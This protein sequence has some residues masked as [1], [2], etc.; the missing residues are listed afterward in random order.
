VTEADLMGAA[1]AALQV[2]LTTSQPV[3]FYEQ[4]RGAVE[5][6]G[7]PPIVVVESSR[8]NPP[9]AEISGVS[10]TPELTLLRFTNVPLGD[11]LGLENRVQALAR[12]APVSVVEY[13]A[14]ALVLQVGMSPTALQ[15][16]LTG[17]LL[18]E[19]GQIHSNGDSVTVERYR[20][21]ETVRASDGNNHTPE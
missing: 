21:A 3:V 16:A 19:P 5:P 15:D 14:G 10:G 13:R 4:V 11:T 12:P 8:P 6:A 1:H 9:S 7:F 18:L 17:A 20:A 2:A